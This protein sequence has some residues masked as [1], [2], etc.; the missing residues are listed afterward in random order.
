MREL[1]LLLTI[2]AGRQG[3]A[4]AAHPLLLWHAQPRLRLLPVCCRGKQQLLLF[5]DRCLIKTAK[6]DIAVPWSAIKNVAV[7]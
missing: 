6:A 4:G 5:P 3:P 2:A 1:Q 7:R